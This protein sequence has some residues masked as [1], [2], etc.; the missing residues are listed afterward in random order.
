[1]SPQGSFTDWSQFTF[2]PSRLKKMKEGG[3]LLKSFLNQTLGRGLLDS[4][5]LDKKV[6]QTLSERLVDAQIPSAARKVTG[7]ANLEISDTGILEIRKILFWLGWLSV[8]LEKWDQLNYLLQLDVWQQC[9][10]TIPKASILNQEKRQDQWR[11]LDISTT[12]EGQLSTRKTIVYGEVI[13][14]CRMVIDYVFGQAKFE[15]Q[16]RLNQ[17]IKSSYVPYPGLSQ[18]RILLLDTEAGLGFRNSLAFSSKIL[19]IQTLRKHLIGVFN[20]NFLTLDHIVIVGGIIPII[21]DGRPAIT[22]GQGD[23]LYLNV[24]DDSFLNYLA[25]AGGMPIA[26][27]ISANINNLRVL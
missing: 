14:E 24:A 3:I 13:K 27:P 18:Q 16:Y 8:Y 19:G 25:W 9:G 4:S 17:F 10:A 11:V 15:R 21:V 1:M 5:V 7:L 6:L 20:Q 12:K 26:V 23:V 22:D 2:N